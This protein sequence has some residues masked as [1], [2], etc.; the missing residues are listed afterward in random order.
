[1]RLDIKL[2]PDKVSGIYVKLTDSI[3]KGFTVPS[4]PH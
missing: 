2:P 1:M 4:K 3:I